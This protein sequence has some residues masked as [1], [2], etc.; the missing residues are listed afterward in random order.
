MNGNKIKL[1]IIGLGHVASYQ[2]QALEYI[3][4]FELVAICDTHKNKKNQFPDRIPF[5]TNYDDMI[6]TIDMDAVLISVPNKY[7]YEVAKKI[8]ESNK[9]VL[10]EKP[11]TLNIKQFEELINI[12]RTKGLT[13]V[14]AFHAAFAKDLLW[15]L[16]NYET[17]LYKELGNIT[18]F[19]CNFYDP[20]IVNGVLLKHIESLD[21]SWIDSGINALSVIGKLVNNL[22][23]EEAVLTQV[24]QYNC[25][26]IQGALNFLFP[27]DK[28]DKAGR[29]TIDTNWTLGLNCKITRLYFTNKKK[30]I[31]LHH[32]NQQV[33]LVDENRNMKLLIDCSCNKPRLVNHYI[34]VFEDFYT[35]KMTGSNNLEYALYL[36]RLLLSA[37]KLK[38]GP[39]LCH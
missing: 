28:I 18:G 7:H 38:K 25:R 31:V 10:L 23:I 17:N 37:Y 11:A 21:G 29:G 32:S 26:E 20:Y 15:F 9:N 34:G 16:E 5:F 19:R 12:A 13:F 6:E 39:L 2:L 24:P 4:K 30:G 8:L 1:A 35:C 14:I 36:H 3:D 22:E 27:I 33:L